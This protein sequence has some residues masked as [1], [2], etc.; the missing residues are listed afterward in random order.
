MLRNKLLRGCGRKANGTERYRAMRG[1]ERA[2]KRLYRAITSQLSQITNTRDRR[3][4]S[5]ALQRNRR[6]GQLNL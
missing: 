6:V 5:A 1:A 2:A 3:I 4:E